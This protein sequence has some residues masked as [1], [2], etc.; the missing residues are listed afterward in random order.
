[1]PEQ[2]SRRG[3]RATRCDLP[4]QSR[5]G[6]VPVLRYA[7][8]FAIAAIGTALLGGTITA[9]AD[10]VPGLRGQTIP[11]HRAGHQAGGRFFI[12]VPVARRRCRSPVCRREGQLHGRPAQRRS[13]GVRRSPRCAAATAPTSSCFN[14]VRPT[15]KPL[16]RRTATSAAITSPSMS[17]T[18]KRR[19]T[20]RRQGRKNLLRSVSGERGSGRRPKHRL[21]PRALGPANGD[22]QLSERDGLREVGSRGAVVAARPGEVTA[23]P[24]R[25]LFPRMVRCDWA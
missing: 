8:C 11:H 25:R 4:S 1:M 15:R 13:A 24:N 5:Q 3:S 17:T 9:R 6:E 22:H 7:R 18:S 12:N 16:R 10:G 14:T 23:D 2:P 21:F 19:R 20:I